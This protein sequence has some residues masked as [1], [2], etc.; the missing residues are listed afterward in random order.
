MT[1]EAASDIAKQRMRETDTER[2]RGEGAIRKRRM[3]REGGRVR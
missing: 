2:H 1:D 3:G